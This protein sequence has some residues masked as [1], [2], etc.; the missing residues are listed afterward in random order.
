MNANFPVKLTRNCN[1]NSLIVWFNFDVKTI[2]VSGFV[3][4]TSC[5]TLTTE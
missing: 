2:A 1:L 3:G 5:Y 4:Q